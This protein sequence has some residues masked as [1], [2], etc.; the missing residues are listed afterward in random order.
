MRV[1][2][3]TDSYSIAGQI[4]PADVAAL[5]AAGFDLIVNNRPDGEA[6]GQPEG[7][8]IAQAAKAAGI[9]YCAIPVGGMGPTMDDIE[10]LAAQM[11]SAG[12]ILAFCYSGGRSAMLWA[13]A[14]ARRGEAPEDVVA[15]ALAAG[16]DLRGL[17]PLLDRLAPSA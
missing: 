16:Q 7:A 11:D 9:G 4:R 3:L 5:R 6:P 10:M 12:K 14:S 13:L 1:T 2:A 17:R 15:Q 8:A